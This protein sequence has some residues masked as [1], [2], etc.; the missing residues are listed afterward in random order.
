[1]NTSPEDFGELRKLLKLK[2]Y[3]QPPPGYFAHFS[4]IVINRIERE[5]RSGDAMLEV[6]S[7]VARFFGL[8]QASP[9]FSGLF[10]AALCGLVIFGISTANRGDKSPAMAF[11]PPP[12]TVAE[13]NPAETVAFNA[14]HQGA[15]GRSTDPVFGSAALGS[16]FAANGS[17]DARFQ[18][19]SFTPAP[20]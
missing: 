2:R 15:L 7:W 1:M 5:G 11:Q 4:T 12:A 6:P 3:E 14:S 20:Q 16:P 10:G 19:A 9:V 13:A 17:I 18:N 8:F